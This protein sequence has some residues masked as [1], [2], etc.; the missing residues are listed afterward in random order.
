[1]FP[2]CLCLSYYLC[3]ATSALQTSVAYNGT[4]VHVRRWLRAISRPRSVLQSRDIL[5]EALH[6][7]AGCSGRC[8]GE[9]P[10][11][12]A[13]RPVQE[14]CSVRWNYHVQGFRQEVKGLF[15]PAFSPLRF[16]SMVTMNKTHYYYYAV[17]GFYLRQGV[18]AIGPHRVL[19]FY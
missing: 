19:I 2:P 15:L 13:Q 14:Y 1:M 6:P 18:C 16:K 8:G 9:V 12:C 11:R 4:T 5:P 3:L 17:T 10:H 7:P